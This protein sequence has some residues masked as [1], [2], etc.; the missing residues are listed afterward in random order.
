MRFMPIAVAV[1]LMFAGAATSVFS[2]RPDDQIDARSLAF[3]A[4]GQAAEKAGDLA[5]ANDLIETSL[6]IDPRNRAAYIALG[7]IARAQDLPGK[8]IRFYREAL[9]LEPNDVTALAG[10]GEAMVQKGA[11]ESAKANL[12]RIRTICNAECP[13]ATLL[14]A[15]IA[16]GPPPA[17]VTAEAATKVPPK[18]EEAKPKKP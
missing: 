3:L 7:R 11:V 18:G 9:A 17:V 12:V 15:T 8:S 4:D 16:K 1:S 14:A 5:R 2:Q 13:S 6:A 10:Q